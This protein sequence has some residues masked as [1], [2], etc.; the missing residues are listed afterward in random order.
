MLRK[1]EREREMKK[2]KKKAFCKLETVQSEPSHLYLVSSVSGL[3]EGEGLRGGFRALRVKPTLQLTRCS[4]YPKAGKNTV[5]YNVRISILRNFKG[6]TC[7]FDMHVNT[8]YVGSIY[9]CLTICVRSCHTS[10][11]WRLGIAFLVVENTRNIGRS[12]PSCHIA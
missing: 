3:D 6:I 7:E 8:T 2:K 1:H 10:A 4:M 5:R 12:C 11:V 9:L